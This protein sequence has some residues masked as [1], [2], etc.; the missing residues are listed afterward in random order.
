MADP[1]MIPDVDIQA[2]KPKDPAKLGMIVDTF[3]NLIE[4]IDDDAACFFA[5]ALLMN[6]LT[7]LARPSDPAK[8]IRDLNA[9]FLDVP[10][11]GPLAATV[12]PPIPVREAN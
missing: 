6:D 3:A 8:M 7:N 1:V 9:F 4:F 11:D 5:L 12:V 2:L 10:C